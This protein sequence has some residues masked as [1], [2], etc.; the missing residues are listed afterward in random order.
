MRGQIEHGPPF[1]LLLAF[2]IFGF[3]VPMDSSQSYSFKTNGRNRSTAR[4]YH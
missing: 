3:F 4:I 2:G 1:Q